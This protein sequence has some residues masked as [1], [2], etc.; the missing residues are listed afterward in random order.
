MRVLNLTRRRAA[1][2]LGIAFIVAVLLVAGLVAYGI[3]FL[4]LPYPQDD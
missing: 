1:I 3:R 4:S 2:E